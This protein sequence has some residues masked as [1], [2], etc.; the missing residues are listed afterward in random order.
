M[1]LSSVGIAPD[2]PTD[3]CLAVYVDVE[4]GEFWFQ[5]DAVTDPQRC[6]ESRHTAL[7]SE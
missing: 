6:A 4:C 3:E 5:G 7:E 1:R 2:T